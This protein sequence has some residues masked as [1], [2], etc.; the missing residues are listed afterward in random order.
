MA[1]SE[2]GNGVDITAYNAA[3]A[4]ARLALLSTGDSDEAEGRGQ[5]GERNIAISFD[6]C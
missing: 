6:R 1:D 4:S 5:V 3:E 2:T